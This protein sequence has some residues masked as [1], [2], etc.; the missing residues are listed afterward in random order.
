MPSAP[1]KQNST[2]RRGSSPPESL[3]TSR[4][5]NSSAT[6]GSSLLLPRSRGRKRYGSSTILVCAGAEVTRSNRILK[7]SGLMRGATCSTR[8]RR[9]MK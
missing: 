9:T 5:A 6:F 2:K 4:A 1:T 7:P 8:L 3:E